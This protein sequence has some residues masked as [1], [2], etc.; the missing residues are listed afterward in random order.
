[1]NRYTPIVEKAVL[2][3]DFL[4]PGIGILVVPPGQHALVAQA[5]EPRL[6]GAVSA[7]LEKGL[8]KAG[9]ARWLVT[10][11]PEK[12]D[13]AEAAL[14]EL[15]GRRGWIIQS[16]RLIVLLLTRRELS[17][18][19]RL[20]GDVYSAQ[21]FSKTIPFVPD[22]AVD[23]EAARVEL[24]R[25]QRSRFGHLDLRGFIRAE[26]EDV[27]W[28]VEE[29]Y[30][31]LHA[32]EAHGGGSEEESRVKQG[33]QSLQQWLQL[34]YSSDSR[35]EKP[36]V[37][38]GHPGSGKTFFLRWLAVTSAESKSFCGMVR[39]LPLL[40]SLSAYAQAPGPVS[41]L[42]HLTET[43]LEGG[44][45]AAHG[46][47][48]AVA[49]R[50]ALFLLDGLDEAGDESA[51]RRMVEAVKVLVQEVPGCMVVVT[52]RIAGYAAVALPAHELILEP[53]GDSSIRNF[54]VRWCELYTRD[55]LGETSE[56][57]SAGRKEG[58]RLAQDV[59]DHPQVHALA[60]NPLLLTILALVHRAGVRLPEHRVEFYEHTTR[61]LVE[62]WN[63][64]RSLHLDSRV[65]P[66]KVADAVRLLGPVALEIIRSGTRGAITEARLRELLRRSLKSSHSR[67]LA[68]EDEAIE[69]FRNA[70]GL[71]VEQGPGI[72]SFLHLTLAEYLAARELVRSDELEQLAGNEQDAF[73]PEAREVLLLAA[74]ELGIIRADDERLDGLVDLLLENAARQERNPA[75]SVPS[76]LA[77]LLADDPGFSVRAAERLIQALIP[78]WWFARI[79]PLDM[80]RSVAIE[81]H[82]LMSQRLSK[83]RF[84]KQ[85][86]SRLEACYG[87]E[88]APETLQENLSCFRSIVYLS[89]ASDVFQAAEMDYGYLF[90]QHVRQQDARGANARL[91][92]R[93]ERIAKLDGKELVVH[94]CVSRFL[95]QQVRAGAASLLI[96]TELNKR[97][98]MFEAETLVDYY[99][100]IVVGS[101][102]F[103]WTKTHLVRELDRAEVLIEVRL[104][105]KPG[106]KHT[107][108]NGD[109]FVS[110]R[111]RPSR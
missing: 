96:E 13:E 23:T 93:E 16:G 5:L 48:R 86:R 28:G 95:D 78:K 35:R 9:A 20:A 84:A 60:R 82:L 15:N 12:K 109:M 2:D 81:A 33:S 21:L 7:P 70:L 107:S 69:L 42:A 91:P 38:L 32:S 79:Y 18:M 57:R 71:L 68:S 108:D 89:Y 88:A 97:R 46:V 61:I 66:L 53:L 41:L 55:R 54:L 63:R 29:I 103:P 3:A 44:Q 76:L 27:S 30:Q 45:W 43:L 111:I 92:I 83:G 4:S 31:E 22:L 10:G 64:V 24:A 94:I 58:E 37:I 80:M 26:S 49:E 75:V 85:I 99:K 65:P 50:R 19:Q 90:L 59:L 11:L 14:S 62:R 87:H 77:G 73:R 34:H 105:V 56:A 6:P 17:E 74:G 25:W 39:P 36:L 72:Y 67:G 98:E 51:R 106:Y 40:A 101:W 8:L 100:S 110:S 1:M 52:S 47:A 102:T 104:A